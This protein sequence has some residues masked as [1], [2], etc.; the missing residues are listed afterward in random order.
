MNVSPDPCAVSIRPIIGQTL[1]TSEAL[2]ILVAQELRL[3][4]RMSLAT[5]IDFIP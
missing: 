1:P 4:V 2:V 5:T 3:P